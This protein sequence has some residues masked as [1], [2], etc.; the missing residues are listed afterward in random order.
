MNQQTMTIDEGLLPRTRRKPNPSIERGVPPSG[1]RTA[2]QLR[3]P[4]RPEA[5][6]W[7]P[8]TTPRWLQSHSQAVGTVAGIRRSPRRASATLFGRVDRRC[9]IL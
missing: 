3:Q 6:D 7:R 1:E 4:H 2:V 9:V 8:A 5:V